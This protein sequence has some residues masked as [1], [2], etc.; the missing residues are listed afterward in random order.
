MKK[1]RL[2]GWAFS[3]RVG[4]FRTPRSFRSCAGTAT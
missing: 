3:C 2:I 1:P 4:L